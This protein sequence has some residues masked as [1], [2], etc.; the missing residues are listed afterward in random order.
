MNQI[1]QRIIAN[2]SA[3]D[4]ESRIA[5]RQTAEHVARVRELRSAWNAPKRH[6]LAN[7]PRDGPWGQKLVALETRLGQGVLIGLV[8]NR[9]AGKTQLAVELM[10]Q[11]VQK[12]RPALFRTAM[13]IFMRFKA[14]YRSGSAESEL[15][16]L[17]AHRRPSLLVIDEVARRGESEWE[18]NMLF[19]LLNQRY[20]DM[21]DTILTCNL[22]AAELEASLGLR[23][24]AKAD[25]DSD[26]NRTPVP[27]HIGQ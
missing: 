27:I 18:N 9:G 14:S 1:L 19:E 17:R 6:A 24:P 12:G 7:P 2:R 10:K 23:I 13:E 11:L 25:T 16:I 22:S 4:L 20:A 21:T 8:G 5:E 3:D 15:D 26:P